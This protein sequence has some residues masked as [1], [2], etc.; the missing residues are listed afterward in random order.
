MTPEP[1]KKKII[2]LLYG[3]TKGLPSETKIAEAY[4]MLKHQGL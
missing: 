2:E 3:W 1:V 4:K